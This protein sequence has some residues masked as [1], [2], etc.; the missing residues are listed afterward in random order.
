MVTFFCSCCHSLEAPSDCLF[1]KAE[2]VRGR[3]GCSSLHPFSCTWGQQER[4]PMAKSAPIPHPTVSC[5]LLAP[6]AWWGAGNQNTGWHYLK[7]APC[8]LKW[9]DSFACLFSNPFIKRCISGDAKVSW[10]FIQVPGDWL[11][12]D[13]LALECWSA[14]FC[15]CRHLLVN[16]ATSIY[17]TS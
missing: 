4:S 13:G 10:N 9:E 1:V 8:A 14:V 5:C 12:N 11:R 15:H 17:K 16:P 6:V 7:D 3:A 2:L